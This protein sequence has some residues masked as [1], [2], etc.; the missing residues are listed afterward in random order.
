[1]KEDLTINHP[2]ILSPSSPEWV[3]TSDSSKGLLNIGRDETVKFACVAAKMSPKNSFKNP[4]LNVENVVT[5]TC[6]NG[7]NFEINKKVYNFDDLMCNSPVEATEKFTNQD[8]LGKDTELIKV[9]FQVGHNFVTEY[10]VCFD[11]KE[12]HTLYSEVVISG[13]I[14]KSVVHKKEHTWLPKNYE[15]FRNINMNNLYTCNSQIDTFKKILNKNYFEGNKC[16]LEKTKLVNED[17]MMFLPE[18]A[19]TSHYLNVVP[20]WSTCNRVRFFKFVLN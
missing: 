6:K 16:C 13:D 10:E 17:N 12:R 11:K 8:C 7:N 3:S 2:L 19:S 5:A 1:M 15:S 9:G 14:D 4:A 18:Q 20:Q